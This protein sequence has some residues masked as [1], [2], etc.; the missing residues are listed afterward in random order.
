MLK[1]K[2]DKVT[3][4]RVY[5]IAPSWLPSPVVLNL[6][7]ELVHYFRALPGSHVLLFLALEAHK[8]IVDLLEYS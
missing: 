1:I 3:I 5:L 8:Q 7:L 2:I 4:I 6:V